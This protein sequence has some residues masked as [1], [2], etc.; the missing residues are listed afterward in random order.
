ML[1]NWRC[2]RVGNSNAVWFERG[3]VGRRPL[4][5]HRD[6]ERPTPPSGVLQGNDR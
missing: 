1:N 6:R 5:S 4:D 3:S 2:I